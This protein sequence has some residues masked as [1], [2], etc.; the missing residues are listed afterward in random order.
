MCIH[1]QNNQQ[2]I[3]AA[4]ELLRPKHNA[5]K[6]YR[7]SYYIVMSRSDSKIDPH[8]SKYDLV[9][10]GACEDFCENCI[11]SALKDWK[12]KFF[13]ERARLLVKLAMFIEFGY[14]VERRYNGGKTQHEE[15]LCQVSDD[16]VLVKIK[17]SK[18]RN[19]IV[20]PSEL[21]INHKLRTEYRAK[22]KFDYR[23]DNDPSPHF[24]IGFKNCDMCGELFDCFGMHEDEVDH[25]NQQ[26][27]TEYTIESIS[28]YT[29]FELY[30]LFDKYSEV[31]KL[32]DSVV[33]IASRFIEANG[34]TIK[35]TEPAI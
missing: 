15:I 33:A 17:L 1:K 11:Q 7:E 14:Y 27:M 24:G 34:I 25:W 35:T 10:T 21:S 32:E 4:L 30:T 28:N 13:L 29:A 20:K 5:Y 12:E 18:K 3:D 22:T 26:D 23:I 19:G 2:I 31:D 8:C 6:P 9:E 16:K